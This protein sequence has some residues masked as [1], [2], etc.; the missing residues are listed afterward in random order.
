MFEVT[1]HSEASNK[2]KEKSRSHTSKKGVTPLARSVFY[3][4]LSVEDMR[5]KEKTRLS[6]EALDGLR[7]TMGALEEEI[8]CEKSKTL[9]WI[10]KKPFVIATANSLKLE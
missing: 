10:R 1:A 4:S 9:T 6:G 8:D 5:R 3:F 2:T 7:C